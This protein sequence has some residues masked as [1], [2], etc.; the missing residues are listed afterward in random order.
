MRKSRIIQFAVTAVLASIGCGCLL[1]D[2][3][4]FATIC[5]C[6][7]SF[8]LYRR[9]ELSQPV[10]ARE[11]RILVGVLAALI[12][13]IIF[14]VR[15]IPRSSGD[16]FIREPVVVAILWVVLMMTLLWR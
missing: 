12:A 4:G 13:L 9:K 1:G 15:L 3:P 2:A 16:R 10:P 6:L 8:A 5:F 14:G 11:L 7:G